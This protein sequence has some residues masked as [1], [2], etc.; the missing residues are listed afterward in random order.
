MVLCLIPA[1]RNRVRGD[2]DIKSAVAS[3]SLKHKV[4]A[5]NLMEYCI[6]RYYD[7]RSNTYF[8]LNNTCQCARFAYCPICEDFWLWVWDHPTPHDKCVECVYYRAYY[9][10]Q[11]D[12]VETYDLSTQAAEICFSQ[13]KQFSCIFGGS[14]NLRFDGLLVVG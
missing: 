6:N 13:Q 2:M 3:I 12:L 11:Q 8:Y 7:P 9:D 5:R 4:N 10:A 1:L 14:P